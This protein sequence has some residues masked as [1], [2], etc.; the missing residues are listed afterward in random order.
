MD[1]EQKEISFS[2]LVL[3]VKEVISV[4]LAY[5]LVIAGSMIVLGSLAA[6]YAY[7]K[8]P[9]YVGKTT[10]MLDQQGGGKMSSLMGVASSFG[11][12]SSSSSSLTPEKYIGILTSDRVL[13]NTLLKSYDGMTVLEHFI[14][15]V[16]QH[17]EVD[18]LK[19]YNFNNIQS[20]EDSILN[21]LIYDMREIVGS[22]ISDEGVVTIS[23]KS[24]NEVFAYHV[25]NFLLEEV[26]SFFQT[27]NVQKEKFV[28]DQLNA[29][30]D[31]IRA[32]LDFIEIEYAKEKDANL[33]AL[34]ATAKI[35]ELRLMRKV[36]ILN[37][38][39]QE[40]LKKMEL[41]RFN[42][43]NKTAMIQ[44]IDKPVLPL[45]KQIKSWKHYLV[46]GF[47]LGAMLSVISVLLYDKIKNAETSN[48]E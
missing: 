21:D 12:G 29:R 22:D 33:T 5:K 13:R 23:V 35:K 25:T 3:I 34:R 41:A 7:F 36:E 39:Y 47:I 8:A 44:V 32:E 14:I 24:S 10:F 40:A 26:N 17:E 6:S 48:N 43:L 4:L 19:R 15:D 9:T 1:K 42:L 2:E 11:F 37:V 28:F 27:N 30:V 18:Y 45:E 20:A 16:F 31:S 46:Y 38:M